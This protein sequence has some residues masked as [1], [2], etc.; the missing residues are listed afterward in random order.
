MQ[1]FQKQFVLALLGYAVQRNVDPQRLCSLSGIEYKSLIQKTGG[2]VTA[3]ANKLIVEKC[4]S[5][6]Q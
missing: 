6:L 3:F 4:K 5:P 2:H 1:D